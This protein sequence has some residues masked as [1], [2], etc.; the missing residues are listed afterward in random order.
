MCEGTPVVGVLEPFTGDRPPIPGIQI[1]F[2]VREKVVR[3]SWN[4]PY[5]LNTRKSMHYIKNILLS[6]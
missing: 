2:G 4:P 6:F 1:R 5:D 3:T